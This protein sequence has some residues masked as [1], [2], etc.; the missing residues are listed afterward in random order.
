MS[1]TDF[2]SSDEEFTNP[3]TR[4]EPKSSSITTE[5][6]LDSDPEEGFGDIEIPQT[7]Q[8]HSNDLMDWDIPDADTLI[9]R[10]NSKLSKSANNNRIQ[11]TVEKRVMQSS[12][13]STKLQNINILFPQV[14][15]IHEV[16]ST[17]ISISGRGRK[18]PTL[19]S[20][21]IQATPTGNLK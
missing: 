17:E 14:S 7:L 1:D 10:L 3:A 6:I 19:I 20:P 12:N 11:H 15:K 21:T 16:S 9:S 5:I 2:F 8:L 13:N 18:K 4:I